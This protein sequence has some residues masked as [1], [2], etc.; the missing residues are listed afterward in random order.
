MA[1]A[2]GLRTLE[3][4]ALKLMA[5]IGVELPDFVYGEPSRRDVWTKAL[6]TAALEPACRKAAEAVSGVMEDDEG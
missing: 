1:R 6:R 3:F 4:A 5:A 2:N